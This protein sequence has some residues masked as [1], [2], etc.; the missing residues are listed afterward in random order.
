MACF[1]A[2]AIEDN[3]FPPPVGTVSENMP[4][5]LSAALRHWL[6]ISER[7]LF[8]PIFTELARRSSNLLENK[9]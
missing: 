3:V 6:N 9:D 4:E 7:I 2:N 1:N 5:E 8:I